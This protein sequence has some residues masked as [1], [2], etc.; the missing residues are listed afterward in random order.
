MVGIPASPAVNGRGATDVL[1]RIG[2]GPATAGQS[3]GERTPGERF[4]EAVLS[5]VASGT[6]TATDL[7]VPF[8]IHLPAA[9]P[10]FASRPRYTVRHLMKTATVCDGPVSYVYEPPAGR[11]DSGTTYASTPEAAFEPRVTATDLTELSV[12]VPLPAGLLHQ[13]GLLAS[14]VDYRVLVR[15]SARENDALLHGTTDGAITGLLK[16]PGI[17]QRTARSD[18]VTAVTAAAADVEE[19]G[20]SCDGLVAHPAAYWELVRAGALGR[21][22]AAGITVSRTRMI[23][24]DTLLLGDFRAATTLLLPNTGA[25]AVRRADGPEGTDAITASTRIGLAVHLPQHLMR[26]ALK[27]DGSEDG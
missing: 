27:P 16:V 3:T 6:S 17:R 20:G 10:L 26:V 11:L 7:A 9:F 21:L 25:V 15:L 19:T 18:L 1:D 23:P 24:R 13:P 2:P 8:D 12:A 14:F 5:A 22:N 4:A